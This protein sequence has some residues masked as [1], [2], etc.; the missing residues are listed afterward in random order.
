MAKIVDET[1]GWGPITGGHLSSAVVL[2]LIERLLL[3]NLKQNW[4]IISVNDKSVFYIMI[5]IFLR[6]TRKLLTFQFVSAI[7]DLVL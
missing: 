6:R 7:Q 1:V 4:L 2:S 3:E 5:S